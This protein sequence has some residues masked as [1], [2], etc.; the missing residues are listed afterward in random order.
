MS[1][2]IKPAPQGVTAAECAFMDSIGER[3][4]EGPTWYVGTNPTAL[5]V[6]KTCPGLWI[7]YCAHFS[8]TTAEGAGRTPKSAITKLAK[9]VEQSARVYASAAAFARSVVD[10]KQ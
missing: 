4:G 2:Q 10:A 3:F 8:G 1:A 6:Y 7:A 5:R 9:N